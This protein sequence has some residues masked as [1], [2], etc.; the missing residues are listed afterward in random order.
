MFPKICDREE[1]R[2]FQRVTAVPSSSPPENCFW[3]W[4]E[5]ERSRGQSPTHPHH[6]AIDF[7]RGEAGEPE[8]SP[9]LAVGPKLPPFSHRLSPLLSPR[10][11]PPGP[12]SLSAAGRP[13]GSPGTGDK[14]SSADVT[15]PEFRWRNYQQLVWSQQQIHLQIQ[16]QQQQQQH[17]N[18]KNNSLDSVDGAGNHGL[19]PP[20]Q[21]QSSGENSEKSVEEKTK[22]IGDPWENFD[23]HA[24]FLGPTLWEKRLPYDGQDFKLEYVDLEEFL[25]ENGIPVDENGKSNGNQDPMGHPGHSNLSHGFPAPGQFMAGPSRNHGHVQSMSHMKDMPSEYASL[26]RSP[27]P[28]T[29]SAS[30]G[31]RDITPAVSPDSTQ[32]PAELGLVPGH[33]FDPRRRAFTEDELKP[34]PMI[35]RKSVV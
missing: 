12:T 26:S 18:S 1:T 31:S 13:G 14:M 33:E 27:S 22:E 19:L 29:S 17:Q 3:S 6:S 28:S 7:E 21:Q 15:S 34:Q 10:P 16:Q 23:A 32:P 11:S 9:G 5:S 30:S 4:G 25:T 2:S 20:H 8:L 35:D 24:A